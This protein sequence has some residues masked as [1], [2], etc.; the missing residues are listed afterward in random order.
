ML[1]EGDIFELKEGMRVYAWLPKHFLFTNCRGNFKDWGRGSV[2]VDGHLSY[3]AGRY[4]VYKTTMDGGSRD[5]LSLYPDGHHVFAEK[6]DDPNMQI[7]F[8]QSGSF[9]VINPEV[10]VIG[11]AS[12]RWVDESSSVS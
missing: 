2:T 12:R 1:Q 8:Y 11:R 3:L 9:G 4:V 10:P 7:D 6:A 5:G